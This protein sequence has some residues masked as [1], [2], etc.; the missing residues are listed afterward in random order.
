MQNETC[1]NE[2]AVLEA[3]RSGRWEASLAAHFESC[4]HC[5]EAV[6]VAGWMVSMAAATAKHR[7]LPDPDL[8]WIKSQLFARQE[9][10][11]R[12]LQPLYLGETLAR[13]LVG[14]FAAAWLALS[15]P[16]M[17]SYLAGLWGQS[18]GTALAQ[19]SANPWPVTLISVGAALALV[20]IVRIVHPLLTRE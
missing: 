13:A 2:T 15:W 9:A 11:D 5:R 14:A 8:L 6:R 1:P 17:M 16:S 18:G 20:G 7:P 19:S 4:P 3:E 10:A 12:A